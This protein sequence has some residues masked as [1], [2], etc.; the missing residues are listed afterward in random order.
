M[1]LKETFLKYS[2]L[3]RNA[4]NYKEAYGTFDPRTVEAY[5]RANKVKRQVMDEI[6]ELEEYKSM[7]EG[8]NK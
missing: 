2:E 7:Y 8:L 6:D 1:P 3:Q 5:E 4:R